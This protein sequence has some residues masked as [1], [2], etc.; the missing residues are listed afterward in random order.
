VPAVAAITVL[1]LLAGAAVAVGEGQPAVQPR[2]GP[3]VFWLPTTPRSTLTLIDAAS[4][5]PAAEIA[6]AATV[7]DLDSGERSYL[8]E[9]SGKL[10][11]LEA[12]EVVTVATTSGQFTPTAVRAGVEGAYLLD[13]DD[14]LVRFVTVGAGGQAPRLGAPI[15]MGG[16]VQSAVVDDAGTLW[17]VLG[18]AGIVASVSAAGD[19]T[20]T[21]ACTGGDNDCVLT[22]LNGAAVVVD[23]GTATAT[24]LPRG[25]RISLPL[26]A[27]R[28]LVGGDSDALALLDPATGALMLTDL[29]RV[30]TLPSSGSVRRPGSLGLGAGRVAVGDDA[31]GSVLLVPTDGSPPTV[32]PVRSDPG[33]VEISAADGFIVLND[34]DSDTAVVVS[35][36]GVAPITKHDPSIAV[37]STGP[38]GELPLATPGPPS[39]EPS[40]LAPPVASATPSATATLTL[41]PLPLGPPQT[42]STA[43]A[44]AGG[45]APT[46]P[47]QPGTDR[48][49]P[50][51]TQPDQPQPV[52]TQPDQPQPDQP[53]P[54]QP[55]PGQSPSTGPSTVPVTPASPTTST[56]STSIPVPDPPGVPLVEASSPD[57][58]SLVLDYTPGAGGPVSDWSV[59]IVDAASGSAIVPAAL[60]V[61]PMGFVVSVSGCGRYSAVV[62]ATGP[63]GQ[64]A[65]AET[66]AIGLCPQPLAA[67]A[68]VLVDAVGSDSASLSWNPLPEGVSAHVEVVEVDADVRFAPSKQ[69]SAVVGGLPSNTPLTVRVSAI[70]QWGRTAT[71]TVDLLTFPGRAAICESWVGAPL[72]KVPTTY[73]WQRCPGGTG[74]AFTLFDSAQPARGIVSEVWVYQRQLGGTATYRLGIAGPGGDWM[75]A[76]AEGWTRV[77]PLGYLAPVE[78]TPATQLIAHHAEFDQM[79]PVWRYLPAGTDPGQGLVEPFASAFTASTEVVLVP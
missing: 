55:Q 62:R 78:F 32:V 70:D 74:G 22:T 1:T 68:G 63:G 56:P 3:A 72:S 25:R 10:S 65:S 30:W 24:E 19:L 14:G 71:S 51:Q 38:D 43:R 60:T 77:E 27:S 66:P 4:A 44:P 52:Q 39:N 12:A 23:G 76:Q 50:V 45:P 16:P 35:E 67:P 9:S 37:T 34:P 7:V 48:P 59:E 8:L 58:T 57:G 17:A 54:D 26:S 29:D 18:G 11:V 13:T 64:T 31:D 15:E 53:Q 75:P 6:T 2:L 69:P 21:R 36:D 47:P 49:R 79:V 40:T 46:Q 41:P 73:H 28:V 33:P 20:S 42:S 5:R 61:Q